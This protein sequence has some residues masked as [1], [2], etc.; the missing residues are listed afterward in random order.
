MNPPDLEAS[1]ESAV[2]AVQGAAR[3]IRRH[4]YQ[5]PT[6]APKA[7]GS[8]VS[9]LDRLSEELMR[10]LLRAA[11][12][13]HTI[14]GE[15]GAFEPGSS[16]WLWYL[17]PLDG[18]RAFSA[19]QDTCCVAAVLA[20]EGVPLLAA[21]AAPFAGE[22]YTAVRG[23]PSRV[24]GHPVRVLSPRPMEEAE[25][26][27]YY[28]APEAGR[29][30]LYGAAGRGEL[31]RISILPGSFILNACRAARGAYDA[32]LCVKRHA[33]PLMPWDLAPASLVLAGAGGLLQDLEGRP[34]GGMIPAREAVAGAPGAAERIIDLFGEKIRDSLASLRWAR[35]CEVVFARL[36]A[37][38]LG[39]GGNRVVGI[40]GAGGGIGKTSFARELASLLGDQNC[41]I[42]SLD[43]YL[44][45]RME[46]DARGIGA[47]DPA[48]TNL[49][50]AAAHLA[51]L[52]RGEACEK[53]VYDHVAGRADRTETVHP[54]RYLIVEGVMALHPI[55]RPTI[56]LAVFLD[57]TS[58]VRFGRVARDREE[59]GL[60]KAYAR[61]VHERYE[62]DCRRHLLPLRA[63]ADVV[64]A[65]DESFNLRW[66]SPE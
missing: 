46:R 39:A 19:G 37:R 65:V 54:A 8:A 58:A 24:N 47:H 4:R 11:H 2:R 1:L 6:T 50:A 38:A 22:I 59:K 51:C 45:Q 27:L 10:R 26:L 57:A 12:P 60:S 31:G 55:L 34:I 44:I 32:Y 35:R 43:D 23:H 61:S 63:T 29:S 52:R 41:R 53:P 30:A 66:V 9:H 64:I 14:V 3:L 36:C 49:E 40:G 28:D 20:R 21:V 7:D 16:G 56:D 33:G 62:E 25:I 13:E 42:M 5:P 15:E 48:A 18:T 17:D